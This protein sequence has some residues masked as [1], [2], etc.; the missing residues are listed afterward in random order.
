MFDP[1]APTVRVVPLVMRVWFRPIVPLVPMIPADAIP[2]TRDQDHSSRYAKHN[3]YLSHNQHTR[4]IEQNRY[5]RHIQT[6]ERIRY[7]RYSL[8]FVRLRGSGQ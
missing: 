7:D 3:R 1:I 6:I 2:E 8:T 4:L 5:D